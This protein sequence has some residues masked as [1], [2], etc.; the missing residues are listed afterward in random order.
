MPNVRDSVLVLANLLET[1]RTEDLSEAGAPVAAKTGSTFRPMQK[2]ARVSHIY[3]CRHV[4]VSGRFAMLDAGIGFTLVPWKPV[5]EKRLGRTMSA[6]VR[7][8]SVSWMF[9]R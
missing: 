9:A 8:A 6:F 1:L 5:I 2:D 4:L 7:G 3:R